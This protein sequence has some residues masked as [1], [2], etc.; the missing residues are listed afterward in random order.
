MRP[1]LLGTLQKSKGLALRFS[2]TP[3]GYC[4]R[5]AGIR[6]ARWAQWVETLSIEG[7]GKWAPDRNILL[8]G[9]FNKEIILPWSAPEYPIDLALYDV[10]SRQAE[11]LLAATDEYEFWAKS[12]DGPNGVVY[13]KHYFED[14]S[15]EEGRLYIVED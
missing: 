9:L 15:V 10:E 2:S 13:E 7:T 12:W 4:Y 11:I 3:S 6:T 8:V 5:A 14:R 1:F